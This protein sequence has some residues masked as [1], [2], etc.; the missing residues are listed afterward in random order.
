MQN[1]LNGKVVVVTGAAS[2]LGLGTSRALAS[3]GARLALIDFNTE[4][5]A[6]AAE[7]IGG[8][9]LGIVADISDVD[10]I[11]RAFGLIVDRFGSIDIVMACAGIVGAGT[12]LQVDPNV[13]ERT[14]EVNVLGTW[15]TVRAALPHL[16]ASKGYLL[17][18]SSGFAAAPGPYNS[19]YAASKAA[20]ESLGRS[21]RIEIAH[22]GVDVGVAYYS[23]LDTPMVEAIQHDQAAMRVRS[24]MPAPVR[25]TYP[26][27]KA[28]EA[29]VSGIER[30]SNRVIYPG[31]LRWQ[32]L[33]R[34]VF[35]P[36]TEGPWR[37]VMAEVEKLERTRTPD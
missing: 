12:V 1:D 35:G 28:V 19:A 8:N 15:R 36:R 3:R 16:V 4:A 6:S 23:F 11:R 18:I 26:L 14:I 27:D 2:G 31:F 32:L 37:K 24:V 21:L 25:K 10:A 9:A 34:G 17:I 22:H 13:W 29:T 20:L 7:S 33:L 30:R 5:V